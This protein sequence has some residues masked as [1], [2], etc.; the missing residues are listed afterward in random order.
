M[1]KLLTIFGS[2]IAGFITLLVLIAIK[3]PI[4]SNLKHIEPTFNKLMDGLSNIKH[5]Y[6][7]ETT[8]HDSIDTAYSTIE[9]N[10]LKSI[11]E[12]ISNQ[13]IKTTK[14]TVQL[15]L[16]DD[17]NNEK[18]STNTLITNNMYTPE[19]L[20]QSTTENNYTT[21]SSI[22]STTE[23]NYTPELLIQSTTENNYTTES[24]IQSTTENNYTTESLIQSTT[25]NINNNITNEITA[26]KDL[27]RKIDIIFE[28]I[29]FKYYIDLK[30]HITMFENNQQLTGKS[31]KL[32]ACLFDPNE[33]YKKIKNSENLY[34]PDLIK[35]NPGISDDLVKANYWIHYNIDLINNTNLKT[36]NLMN[37][38]DIIFQ[39]ILNME[40]GKNDIIYNI[41]TFS[42]DT[43]ISLT[44]NED[45]KILEQRINKQIRGV[46]KK[47]HEIKFLIRTNEY[48][49]SESNKH[50]IFDKTRE[51]EDMIRSI[52]LIYISLE[53]SLK[54]VND[55]HNLIFQMAE[56]IMLFQNLFNE[57]LAF[58]KETKCWRKCNNYIPKIGLFVKKSEETRTFLIGLYNK[59]IIRK[60]E[61]EKKCSYMNK[62]CSKY[63]M[64]YF[65]R[66]EH[67][68]G[69]SEKKI[70]IY[71]EFC[72]KIQKLTKYKNTKK[73]N[74]NYKLFIFEGRIYF[75]HLKIEK[76]DH[77]MPVVIN[78][79][80]E[81][82]IA[83]SETSEENISLE[84]KKFVE[85]YILKLIRFKF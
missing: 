44:D 79:I 62:L 1:Y 4:T 9:T 80:E 60:T 75:Q 58:Q 18:T 21:E 45:L 28:E 37:Y 57:I 14:P 20:I 51:I 64:E 36:I 61:I 52:N 35:N 47:R 38:L 16:L 26:N 42:L 81:F 59:F 78:I 83:F 66:G 15:K 32:N 70:A 24:F 19:S 7:L 53:K 55:L 48:I 49:I 3:S 82:E 31:Q 76:G 22:K 56:S 67:A 5:K 84:I 17:K 41:K 77:E 30:F 8:I 65:Q 29:N 54:M 13:E 33:L 39:N 68:T 63:D 85:D 40:K 12:L 2:I 73:V 11:T 69:I 72:Q 6:P 46:S 25:G 27:H 10:P 43:S 50:L 23:N 74:Y 34:K 71:S